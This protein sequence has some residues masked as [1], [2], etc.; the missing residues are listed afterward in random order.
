MS[1]AKIT[2]PS[3]VPIQETAKVLGMLI[4]WVLR[5]KIAATRRPRFREENATREE[6]DPQ[7]DLEERRKDKGLDRGVEA[8]G[9]GKAACH[10]HGEHGTEPM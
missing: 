2:P 9:I 6:Y 1:S 8:S 7:V 5:S 10:H 3:G 4:Q